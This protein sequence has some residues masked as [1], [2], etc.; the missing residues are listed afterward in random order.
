M[1]IDISCKHMTNSHLHDTSYLSHRMLSLRQTFDQRIDCTH[2]RMYLMDI[3]IDYFDKR[4]IDLEN[5]D[6]T[7]DCILMID[8]SCRIEFHQQ[9]YWLMMQKQF[10]Q[11]GSMRHIIDKQMCQT[12]KYDRKDF[13]GINKRNCVSIELRSY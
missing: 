1:D 11:Y 8:Q 9:Y 7:S 10:V 4:D 12:Q 13:D 5:N 2:S 3:D 6:H